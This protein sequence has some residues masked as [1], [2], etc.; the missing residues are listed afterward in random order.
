M[1]VQKRIGALGLAF[2]AKPDRWVG[3]RPTLPD[4]VPA[5]GRLKRAPRILYAFGHG[6]LGLTMSAVTGEVVADLAT[7]RP[8]SIDL[9]AFGLE[10]FGDLS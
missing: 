9:D 10:R 4:Y 6:H 7:G 5:I 3:A 1:R 8:A 2:A